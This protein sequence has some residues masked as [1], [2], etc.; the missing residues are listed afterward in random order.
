MKDKNYVDINTFTL[1]VSKDL[2][3]KGNKVIHIAD[4]TSTTDGSNERY[5]DTKTSNYLKTESTRVMTGNL[6]MNSRSII[7]V[8]TAHAHESTHAADVN[9]VNTTINNSNKPMITHYQKYVN[10]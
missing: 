3:M 6:N 8:E 9:S 7:N 4:L 5:V 2:D 10:D 1:G